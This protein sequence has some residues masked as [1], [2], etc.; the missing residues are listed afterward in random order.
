LVF[1][2]APVELGVQFQ[3]RLLGP[4]QAPLARHAVT[5]AFDKLCCSFSISRGNASAG[6]AFRDTP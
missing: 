1:E 5:L 2:T 6:S 4:G 3:Q